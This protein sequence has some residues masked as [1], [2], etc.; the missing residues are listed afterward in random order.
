MCPSKIGKIK[1]KVIDFLSALFHNVLI[2]LLISLLLGASLLTYIGI[3][4]DVLYYNVQIWQIIAFTLGAI[5]VYFLVMWGIFRN[6]YEVIRYNLLWKIATIKNKVISLSGS[7][8][9]L[10]LRCISYFRIHHC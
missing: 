1:K 9:R 2:Q 3:L 6:K 8:S 7:L 4:N 10:R 5:F